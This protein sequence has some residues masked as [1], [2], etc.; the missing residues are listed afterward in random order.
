MEFLPGTGALLA[1]PP[2]QERFTFA[3]EAIDACRMTYETSRDGK[4]WQLGDFLLFRK[5]R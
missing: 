4:A 5:I 3:R 2:M 1:P